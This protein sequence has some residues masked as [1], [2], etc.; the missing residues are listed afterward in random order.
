MIEQGAARKRRRD[1][2][3]LKVKWSRRPDSDF[4]P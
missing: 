2:I 4:E 1:S 3:C